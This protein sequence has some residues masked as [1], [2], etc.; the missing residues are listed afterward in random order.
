MIDIGP[1]VKSDK[2]FVA[3]CRLHQSK[4]R[5][6]DLKEEC[7]F[8][9]TVNSETAF[10]NYLKNGED[11][12]HNFISDSA[13]RYAKQR[14][15]DKTICPELTIDTY[16]LFNNMLSSMPLCFNL[17]S[18]LRDLLLINSIECSS[19]V[20]ALFKELNWID[21]VEYI[22]VEFIPIPI[23]AYIDDKSAFDAIVLVKDSFGKLGIVSIETK[24]TDLLGVNTSAK[25][26]QKNKIIQDD[27]LF[28][29]EITQRLLTEGYKQNYRN[30]LLTYTYAKRNQMAN[31]ANIIISP[32]EDVLSIEEYE[33]LSKG[34]RNL[35]NVIFKTDL[36]EFLERGICSGSKR[37]SDV[38]TR[39]K[40]RYI[41]D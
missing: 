25:N 8:G 21:S 3:K 36:D 32:K 19:V 4:Y 37:I 30:F 38:F 18:D 31:F 41:P 29:N 39:I 12:G 24:Y 22:G 26:E 6:L 9:P 28:I 16:R 5:A 7:G 13:F 27:N 2:P 10:G 17:F 40:E 20:K 34:L 11:T 35:K 1:Q 33:E 23:N 14:V 15:R